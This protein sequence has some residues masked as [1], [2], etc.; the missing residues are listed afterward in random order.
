MRFSL[1]TLIVASVAAKAGAWLATRRA[2]FNPQLIRT[3][4]VQSIDGY[5][6]VGEVPRIVEPVLPRLY[7]YDHCPYCVRVRLALGLKN[8]K[9]E[10]VFMS[11]DD[12]ATPT[13]LVGKKIAPIL[14]MPADGVVMAEVRDVDLGP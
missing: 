4:A 14:E 2:P 5:G 13:R 7:V 6:I 3:R 8:I 11:N 1:P 12:V 10:L 9:H